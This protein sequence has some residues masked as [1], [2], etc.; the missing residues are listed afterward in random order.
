M[1]T[2]EAAIAAF[3][4]HY[5]IRLRRDRIG[6]SHWLHH[7]RHEH[8]H[9]VARQDQLPLPGKAA[10]LRK[11]PRDQPVLLRHIINPR[12]RHQALSHNPSLDLIRPPTPP[13]RTVQNLDARNSPTTGNLHPV[14]NLVLHSKPPANSVAGRHAPNPANPK[15]RGGRIAYT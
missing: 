7:K 5:N 2:L 10:P 12:P 8:W 9:P 11:M 3:I 6:R 4:D 13:R 14:L 15:P 1:D